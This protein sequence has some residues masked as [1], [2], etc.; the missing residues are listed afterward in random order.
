MSSG[1]E[2]SLIYSRGRMIRDSS[3]TVGMTKE[4]TNHNAVAKLRVV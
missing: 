4:E 1:V 3:T 2:T